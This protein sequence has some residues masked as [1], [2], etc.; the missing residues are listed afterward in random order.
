MHIIL[1]AA[2]AKDG[3]IGKL[4]TIPWRIKEDMQ[5][6]SS[7][8]T[9]H[10]CIMGK[11]T[12]LSLSDEYRPL[13]NRPNIVVTSNPSVVNGQAHTASTLPEA[14]ALAKTLPGADRIYLIGGSGIYEE[15]MAL[16]DGMEITEVDQTVPGADAYFP[17]WFPHEW[18]EVE[19][20]RGYD[21][22]Y[23]FVNYLRVKQ[24]EP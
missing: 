4:G 14:I 19:R 18:E 5:R 22:G 6:F 12:W 10:P 20:V 15:G 3:A 8:T 1:K 7:D 9:G 13:P 23:E 16:A 2:V 21:P 17:K 24:S 11:K